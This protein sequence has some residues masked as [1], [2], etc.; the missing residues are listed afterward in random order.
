MRMRTILFLATVAFGSTA[1]TC[2]A[3]SA[4]AIAPSTSM[5]AEGVRDAVLDIVER[6]GSRH[7]VQG[8]Q[9]D[10]QPEE[11]W[12]RCFTRETFFLCG[13]LY[14]GEM[15]LRIYQA[16]APRFTPWADS[17]RLELADSLRT[18]FGRAQVRECEWRLSA[19]E[20]GSGCPPVSVPG[21]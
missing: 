2:T 19:A 11:H 7:G 10:Y 8:F 16:R 1:T 4:L 17:T 20:E 21:K 9:P 13:K 14:H 3:F 5:G 15:Q 18:V 12:I 6:I